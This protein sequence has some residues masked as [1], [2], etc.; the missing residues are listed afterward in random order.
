MAGKYE[1]QVRD[2]AI[3]AGKRPDSGQLLAA[4]ALDEGLAAGLPQDEI[5]NNMLSASGKKKHTDYWYNEF[6]K[7]TQQAAV[8]TDSDPNKVSGPT[9][10]NTAEEQQLFEESQ[11]RE[12]TERAQVK[13][14]LQQAEQAAARNPDGKLTP[15]QSEYLNGQLADNTYYQTYYNSPTNTLEDPN[16]TTSSRNPEAYALSK[17][18]KLAD[19]TDATT[20]DVTDKTVNDYNANVE[21]INAYNQAEQAQYQKDLEKYKQTKNQIAEANAYNAKI[22]EDVNA[23]KYDV[24]P[25]AYLT[26]GQASLADIQ[27]IRR[28]R[29]AGQ[30]TVQVGVPEKMDIPAE[31]EEPTLDTIA[32]PDAPQLTEAQ[33]AAYRRKY[34]TDPVFTQAVDYSQP[35]TA[36][37]QE[38]PKSDYDTGATT[39]TDTATA[40]TAAQPA[41]DNLASPTGETTTVK[42]DSAPVTQQVA[43]P[44]PT[45]TQP[46]TGTLYQTAADT[47][48]KTSTT[49]QP[50]TTTAQQ[51]TA[52]PTAQTTDVLS[53]PQST[54]MPTATQVTNEQDEEKIKVA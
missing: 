17:L 1:Q 54:K 7:R 45:T 18:K 36:Q 38:G 2:E 26:S 46:A 43:Q 6:L 9:N 30:T 27:S 14:L 52:A 41:T 19:T 10:T 34:G 11:A 53:T 48:G 49:E 40:D 25:Y 15:A 21:A 39:A 51:Q 32:V 24:N 4:R 16:A 31:L 28:Q 37:L 12:Q 50:T 3:R 29:E 33:A 35:T 23:G 42:Q 20:L 13:T 5:A 44:T 47:N 22:D 8:G